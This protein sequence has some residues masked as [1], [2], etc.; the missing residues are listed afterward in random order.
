MVRELA[1]LM[2]GVN[3]IKNRPIVLKTYFYA[4]DTITKT[5]PQLIVVFV[6]AVGKASKSKCSKKI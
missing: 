3:V 4:N 2:A 6:V 1:R 5:T